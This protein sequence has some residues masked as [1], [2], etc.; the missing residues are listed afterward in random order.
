MVTPPV[1]VITTTIATWGCR[2]RTSTRW[3]VAV[4]IG[5]ADT[6]ARRSVICESC[7]VVALMASSSS[8]RTSVSS[9]GLRIAGSSPSSRSS[10]T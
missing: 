4:S 5:G 10:S 2:G 1:E 8:R 9:S 7:S 3:M 6:S